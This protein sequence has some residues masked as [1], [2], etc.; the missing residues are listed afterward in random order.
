MCL[1][2]CCLI[3]TGPDCRWVPRPIV[4]F[5][6]CLTSS[7]P[8]VERQPILDR[9]WV[10]L[11][12]SSRERLTA[13]GAAFR[14]LSLICAGVWSQ[15]TASTVW[16]SFL[17]WRDLDQ[18]AVSDQPLV[19]ICA[20]RRSRPRPGVRVLRDGWDQL[21]Q[22]VGEC[23][24]RQGDWWPPETEPRSGTLVLRWSRAGPAMALRA[25]VRVFDESAPRSGIILVKYWSNTGQILV[26]YW[27]NTVWDE[28]PRSV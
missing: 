13:S 15:H 19:S 17:G 12:L 16:A 28:H 4:V 25:A 5:D 21:A 24:S 14:C 3:R 1:P 10:V 6:Q 22:V 2:V 11:P 8:G 18:C 7:R 26:K 27:S 23:V 20:A 9:R